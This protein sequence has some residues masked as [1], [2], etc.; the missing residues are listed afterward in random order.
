MARNRPRC[1][2]V[3]R[4][5]QQIAWE[6]RGRWISGTRVVLT[7]TDRCLVQRIEGTVSYVSVTGAY[8]VVDGWHVPC[9]E[10]LGITSP[11]FSQ[12]AA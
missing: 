10:I 6:L 11:H 5:E 12:R 3:E 4:S 9:V 2:A 1:K 8:A 7:L